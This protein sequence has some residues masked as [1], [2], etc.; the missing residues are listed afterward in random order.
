MLICL[1]IGFCGLFN[2]ESGEQMFMVSIVWEIDLLNLPWN[3]DLLKMEGVLSSHRIIVYAID[4]KL[5]RAE[6]FSP[7]FDLMA[8]CVGH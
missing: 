5:L 2:V 6:N 1:W 4:I 7:L 3:V 8:E